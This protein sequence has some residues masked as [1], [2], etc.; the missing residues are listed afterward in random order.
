MPLVV[1]SKIYTIPKEAGSSGPTGKEIVEI[2]NY[3]GLDGLRLIG[4]L[5]P[6]AV[7][8]VGYTKTKALYALAWIAMTRAGEI[9][10]IDDILNEYSIDELD[11]QDE[12]A[13]KKEVTEG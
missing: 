11:F 6:S 10:S 9:L 1:R 7:E 4:T 8:T 2:E 5:A 13:S 3:F 12:D